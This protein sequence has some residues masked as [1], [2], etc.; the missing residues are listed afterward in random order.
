MV[1][2]K[3]K[4]QV[5]YTGLLNE[6]ENPKVTFVNNKKQQ[7]KPQKNNPTKTKPNKKPPTLI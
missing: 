3:S 1:T 4:S 7:K 6:Y 5:S 2:H